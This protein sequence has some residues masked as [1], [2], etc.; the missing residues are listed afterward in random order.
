VKKIVED[1]GGRVAIE[2]RP[3]LGTRVS[4]WLPADAVQ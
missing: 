1:H 3:G 2:S 4:I